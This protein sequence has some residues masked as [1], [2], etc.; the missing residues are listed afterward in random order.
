MKPRIYGSNPDLGAYEFQGAPII[1]DINGIVYVYRHVTT[2]D[3]SGNSW[4]NAVAQL[5]DALQAAIK[6]NAVKQDSIRQIWVAEATYHPLYNAVNGATNGNRDNAFVLVKNV[7]VYGGFPFDA[8]DTDNAPNPYL[9]MEDARNTRNWK[10]YPTVLSG[11][12]GDPT[13]KT[14]D[15]YHVV[16]SADNVD[17]ACLDGFI[18]TKGNA[19]GILNITVNS[20]IIDMS[21]G[22][23]VYCEHSSPLLKNLTIK[24]NTANNNGGGMYVRND[25]DKAKLVSTTIYNNDASYGG[26][27]YAHLSSVALTNVVIDSNKADK[28]GGGIYSFTSSPVFTNLLLI[29]NTA[30]TGAGIYNNLTYLTL[31]NA[32][33]SSNVAE[34]EAGGMYNNGMYYSYTKIRN[35][36]IW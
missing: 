17:T 26:G 8:N 2:G 24:E 36:I 19:D 32:T 4:E 9:S 34:D 35:T 14:D 11:N 16:I 31:T 29:R 28:N 15:C 20:Y 33:I 12:I 10:L 5:A 6:S 30:D 3:G 18:I 25:N 22:G 13:S 27:L 7:Q 1:P 21:N 23:G